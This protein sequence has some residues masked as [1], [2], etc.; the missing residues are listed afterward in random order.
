[1]GPPR[2]PSR[3]T[4]PTGWTSSSDEPSSPPPR[5]HPYRRTLRS[6]PQG[7]RVK[8]SQGTSPHPQP[9]TF[10]PVDLLDLYDPSSCPSF[11]PGRNLS[12]SL[13]ITEPV[14]PTTLTPSSSPLGHI[15]SLPPTLWSPEDPRIPILRSIGF[16]VDGWTFLEGLPTWAR[17]QDF[18]QQHLLGV[19]FNPLDELDR[20]HERQRLHS[21]SFGSED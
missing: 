16:T 13:D 18:E 1:M 20:I 17:V 21:I 11:S 7:I 15:D 10:S 3:I 2:S 6:R 12:P 5:H 19:S 14:L 8:K 4:S 9:R